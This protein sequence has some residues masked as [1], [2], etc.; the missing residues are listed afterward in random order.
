[1]SHCTLADEESLVN[2]GNFDAVIY[3]HRPDLSLGMSV[4]WNLPEQI[5][6]AELH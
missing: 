2:L 6:I 3:Q 5:D 1:M 4:S